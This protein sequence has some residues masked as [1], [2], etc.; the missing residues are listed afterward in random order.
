[1]PDAGL[2]LPVTLAHHLGLKGLVDEHLDLGAKPGRANSGDKVLPLAS[3]TRIG[4][5]AVNER[6]GPPITPG[7]ASRRSDPPEGTPTAGPCP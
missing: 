1:V 2:V 7:R 3:P 4:R 6:L 5:R